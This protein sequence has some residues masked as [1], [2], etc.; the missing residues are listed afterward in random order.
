MHRCLQKYYVV[1]N[2]NFFNK[3]AQMFKKHNFHL[4][5]SCSK[6]FWKWKFSITSLAIKLSSI[7]YLNRTNLTMVLSSTSYIKV[8]K[9]YKNEHFFTLFAVECLQ[10]TIQYKNKNMTSKYQGFLYIYIYNTCEA[11]SRMRQKA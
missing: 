1:G 10:S 5:L 6:I 3:S 4:C 8:F 7:N 2:T 9:M 11:A